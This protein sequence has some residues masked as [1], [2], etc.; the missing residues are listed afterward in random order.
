[1]AAVWR[2]KEDEN[3]WTTELKSLRMAVQV[4]IHRPSEG[5]WW[6]YFAGGHF[7]KLLDVTNLDGAKRAAL[8]Y[9]GRWGR[10]L[11]TLAGDAQEGDW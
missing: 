1:M 11:G 9:V 8:E 5:D 6:V 7:S 4:V 2:Y 3:S 10:E